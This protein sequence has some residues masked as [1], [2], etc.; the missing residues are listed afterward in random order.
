MPVRPP[1]QQS[2]RLYTVG[3]LAILLALASGW[4]VTA[5][6]WSVMFLLGEGWLMAIYSV[7]LLISPALFTMVA[8]AAFRA[9]ATAAAWFLAPLGVKWIA[10]FVYSF[11]EG[12]WEVLVQNLPVANAITRLS[13]EFM[14]QYRLEQVVM[15]IVQFDL[16]P[17]LL[18]VMAVLLLRR[19]RF[20]R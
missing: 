10:V 20:S 12:G 3:Y 4:Y 8:I 16:E 1:Q 19:R 14:M 9:K 11:M 7:V 2:A 13:D 15:L 6:G 18:V 17:L 5:L